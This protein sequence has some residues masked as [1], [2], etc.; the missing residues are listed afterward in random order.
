MEIEDVVAGFVMGL[1]VLGICAL[2]ILMPICLIWSL[3]K[4]FGLGI[5]YTIWTWFAAAFL[6]LLVPSSRIGSR[7][8]KLSRDE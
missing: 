1:V 2:V 8:A 7:I 3:N 6:L 5:P 4:L